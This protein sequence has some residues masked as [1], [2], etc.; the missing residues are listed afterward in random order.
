MASYN[1]T[2]QLL[3][4]KLGLSEEDKVLRYILD[5]YK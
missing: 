2:L 5:V 3:A 4:S 1:K